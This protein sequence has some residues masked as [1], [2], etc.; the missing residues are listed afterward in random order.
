M[1]DDI[2]SNIRINIDAKDAMETIRLLQNQISAFHTQLS[3]MGAASAADARNLQQNLVNSINASGAFS[4]NFT[5]VKTTA[6]SFTQALEKNKLS[7]GEYFR[8][9]GAASKSF[10]RFFQ[11]EFETINKVARERVKDLQTQYIKLGRDANGAMQAIKV[12]PLMLDMD[13]LATKTQIA[14]QR[15][16][17]LNQLLKQGSTNLLNFG[18]NTQWAGR[19]LMVGFTI[20]LSIMGSAA[21]KAYKDIEEAGLRLKR[22]YGDL[23]TTNMETEKMVKQVQQLA[24]E[25][26]KYGVAVKDSMEMAATAA[27]TGK[28]GADLLAQV[29]SA[30]K[31][32]VL[33]GVDQQKALQTTISLTDAFSVSS[34]NLAENI[35]FL[36]AVE[37]QTVLSIDDMT[38]AIP[39]AA[40]VIKQLGGDVKDLAFF[41]TAMKE[42]GVN[43]SEGANA[44][45]SGLA[46]L[47][48]PTNKASEMLAGFGI[49]VKKIVESNK[50]D[51]SKIVVDFAKALD[52]LDPLNRAQA[53]EQLFGKFQFARMSTLFK[54]VIE[55]GSQASEVL[56]LA[57]QSSLELSMLAQ[58]E[59]NKIQQSPLYKFQKAVADFQ[60]QLAPVG[61]QFMKAVTPLI[62]F[63]TDILKGFNNLEDGVKQFIVKIV[64][65]VGVIGPVLIM[66]F[67]LVAN[68]IANVIKGFALVKDMF[69]RAGKS[70]LSLGEQVNYMTQEQLQA[71]AVASS[72]DQVH[73]KLRQTFT[74]EAAAVDMLT[75][76]Y[77]RS[78]AAQNA[79]NVPI[80]PRGPIRKYA[81]GG[82]IHGP[83][84]GTSDSILA[85]VSNGE[86]II[87]AASVARNPEM[88]KQLVSG[89]IPG[90]EKGT[91]FA[92]I[93]ERKRIGAQ[94]LLD[95]ISQDPS[96]VS[97]RTEQVVTGLAKVFGD[98]FLVN[99]YAKLGMRTGLTSEGVSINNLLGKQGVDKAEFLADFDKQGIQRWKDSLKYSGLKLSDVAE[100]LTLLDNAIRE[101]VVRLESNTI[102]D[103]NLKAAYD[104]A[105]QR[106][107]RGGTAIPAFDVLARTAG[108]ARV[109]MSQTMANEAGLAPVAGG[110]SKGAVDINGI[111]LR[112]G[113]DRFTFY[114]K[115]GF[116]L[117][118]EAFIGIKDGMIRG[119]KTITRQKSPSKEAFDAGANIGKGAI[120][121]IQS[122]VDDAKRA[123]TQVGLAVATGA[124][125]AAATQSRRSPRRSQSRGN[126]VYVDGRG[127]VDEGTLQ[128]EAFDAQFI[129]AGNYDR[130]AGPNLPGKGDRLRDRF[131]KLGVANSL[132]RI[133]DMDRQELAGKITSRSFGAGTAL[134]L[135]SMFVPGIAG[136]VMGYAGMASMF[137]PMFSSK[138][139][140]GAQKLLQ[141][142]DLIKLAGKF[143]KLIPYVG[144]A[145]IAFEVFDKAIVPMIKKN[146]DSYEA[147]SKTLQMTQDRMKTINDFFGTDIKLKGISASNISQGGETGVQGSIS[148][149]FRQ[150]QQ[151]KDVYQETATKLKNLSDI[152][153]KKTL[154]ALTSNLFGQAMEKDQVKAIIDAIKTEAGKSSVKIDFESFKI[155]N[156]KNSNFTK[157]IQTA[158]LDFK[159][160]FSA[161]DK[162]PI[163]AYFNAENV[164]KAG[165]AAS[166]LG[167]YIDALSAS[168]QNGA[169]TAKTFNDQFDNLY[170]QL[171]KI[172]SAN[173]ETAFENIRQAVNSANPELATLLSQIK[174][175]DRYLLLLK[176]NSL[177]LS[178]SSDMAAIYAAGTES[179]KATLDRVIKNANKVKQ[180]RDKVTNAYQR[181]IS[182]IQ[183]KQ[184]DISNI[185]QKINDKYNK[186]IAQIEKIK[187]LNDQISKSQEGQ[188]SLAEAL[189]T[190][191]ISAAARAAMEIQQTS[192][193]NA[194]DR[195]QT[196]LD[197][198][199]QAELKPL[200]NSQSANQSQIDT[201]N[202]KIQDANLNAQNVTI[203]IPKSLQ[204]KYEQIT[205]N[206][207]PDF[208]G[209]FN[210]FIDRWANLFNPN[211]NSNKVAP[212]QT[213][214]QLKK[215]PTLWDTIWNA[216][217]TMGV[218]SAT[219]GYITGPGT[220]TS[221]SIPA[222]LSNGEYVI[223]ANAVKTIGVDVLD[224]LN[225]ADKMKFANGGM[226]RGYDQGGVVNSEDTN[227]DWIAKYFGSSKTITP[228]SAGPLLKYLNSIKKQIFDANPNNKEFTPTSLEIFKPRKQTA[229]ERALGLKPG[230]AGWMNLD[231]DTST[232]RI[233]PNEKVTG[234]SVQALLHE[235]GHSIGYQSMK[236]VPGTSTSYSGTNEEI[237]AQIWSGVLQRMSGFKLPKQN[238][239]NPKT[240]I[241]IGNGR[242]GTG[243]QQTMAQYMGY[244]YPEQAFEMLGLT[245]PDKLRGKFSNLRDFGVPSFHSPIGRYGYA[246]GGMVRAA[247]GGVMVN[248]QI[249]GG[250]AEGGF[251]SPRIAERMRRKRKDP[252]S[253]ATNDPMAPWNQGDYLQF[254]DPQTRRQYW[255]MSQEGSR[256]IVNVGKN[257]GYFTPVVGSGLSFGD[258]ATAFGKGD[259]GGGLLNTAFGAGALWIPRALGLIGKGFKAAKSYI[260]APLKKIQ[261]IRKDLDVLSSLNSYKANIKQNPE[262]Q[263]ILKRTTFFTG[264]SA[265]DFKSLVEQINLGKDYKIKASIKDI[266]EE[267]FD[268]DSAFNLMDSIGKI[269]GTIT[270]SQGA[271]VGQF[272]GGL[273]KTDN[274]GVATDGIIIELEKA[275]RR[276]G[277]G[278][279]LTSQ[280]TE[281]FKYAGLDN[282][283]IN[284]A[285]TDGGYAW[286]KAGFKFDGKPENLIKRM[287]RVQTFIKDK[288]LDGIIERLKS[289]DVMPKDIL[290]A[291]NFNWRPLV[292]EPQFIKNMDLNENSKT[293]GELIMRGSNWQGYMSMNSKNKLPSNTIRDIIQTKIA[294][295][296]AKKVLGIMGG[297]D[298]AKL[299]PQIS[300]K[301]TSSGLQGF[302]SDDAY[303]TLHQGV[304]SAAQDDPGF[305]KTIEFSLGINKALDLKPGQS[306]AYGFL[307]SKES[308]PNYYGSI[309]SSIDS[310]EGAKQLATNEFLRM[311]NPNSRALQSYGSNVIN[312]KPSALKNAT[313]SFGDTLSIMQQGGSMA[314]SVA[315]LS[316]LL[317][318]LKLSSLARKT[319]N[320]LGKEFSM[321]YA[322]IH[323]PSGFG[324][325]DVSSI[326]TSN[327]FKDRVPEQIM[328][329]Q[330]M[331]SRAG[332]G[333]ISV[334]D[335]IAAGQNAF[336]KFDKNIPKFANGGMIKA[337][338]GGLLLNGKFFSGFAGGG[339]VPAKFAMGGYAMGTDT[340][341]AM[342]TPGEFVIKKSAVD[343]IGTAT[344]HKLNG[345]AEGGMVGGTSGTSIGDS[346]YNYSVNVNVSSDADPNQIARAVMTQIKQIDNHRIRSSYF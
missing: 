110:G 187:K 38:T 173:P 67:G 316:S 265:S 243:E 124:T 295:M 248:G 155:D 292:S 47:I 176:A 148:E 346:V 97:R 340:V 214:A 244:A 123:G 341:P 57:S 58:R 31:L 306:P 293:L 291:L 85:M 188:L 239:Y 297:S 49:N 119:I 66:S 81:T 178:I 156:G 342:L 319:K 95:I 70:S 227:S 221:D 298:A 120:Q 100:E 314:P 154:Q 229:L 252:N 235:F 96:M 212:G 142:T 147:V 262:M 209:G 132:S 131:S 115:Q 289:Q 193:Q 271:K 258:A 150:S 75:A 305:R 17:L 338:A 233:R 323:L 159:N 165:A 345:Y 143:T 277:L 50:G 268:P 161:N 21:M 40:P 223:R 195:Q 76:A 177:G 82:I 182:K 168:Y 160:T 13:N 128:Q 301:M 318:T 222:M 65:G 4:A 231:P 102:R 134:S 192:A 190:G 122:S 77:K 162:N 245:V 37:N 322:E 69:N 74:S 90:F 42:G 249:V 91:E 202:S 158:I 125:T 210:W 180:E 174:D 112:K 60:A 80:T 163:F 130:P 217:T 234:D 337:A 251:V 93:G 99:V 181:E 238:L 218:T 23:G 226:V 201:L 339:M 26:T 241:W 246:N 9:A 164:A 39:K 35:N 114:S 232:I 184:T 126:L 250:Y 196:A 280:L 189:N 259:I 313:V 20:P 24:L 275:Y 86:A 199:R 56:K 302:I 79:M 88:V 121:G 254:N 106:V 113:G 151:F 296:N 194:L 274:F 144:A 230:M 253:M 183:Q 215:N 331:L 186:R 84:T 206:F 3:K 344:L 166:Q 219:G 41:L 175:V 276:K 286:A 54:N 78:I 118:G 267:E 247:G 98:K 261:G 216:L 55:Q 36:N 72:L 343:R 8:Y 203:N 272:G 141:G 149:Q 211:A 329:I 255:S 224:R 83:G 279:K 324:L 179:E 307:T 94:S 152:E 236:S 59:L 61:E 256:D 105:A 260:T 28:Q 303:K 104:K 311:I 328:E 171:I 191:D 334:Y 321:P 309:Y 288:R 109:N 336:N 285:M 225:H 198:A 300:L 304:R 145:V 290:K 333:N 45:K 330:Q 320:I 34:K 135:G 92:H 278:K 157:G 167:S 269:T 204:G 19:Q 308:V 200:K 108:E 43:A 327:D 64:S 208:M 310:R 11:S 25:F 312:L 51:V 15:Q 317:T 294:N 10:G 101:E 207:A 325:K 53:I 16:Q 46:S 205:S 22:V 1:A 299:T 137:A 240:N 332:Y 33:G 335:F 284:A 68:A 62:N 73:S 44:I 169:I 52:T 228:K 14:A 266:E 129:P 12:R 287:E 48:N 139:A 136:Q 133:R 213:I 107:G 2:Q 29:S 281:L 116:S 127:Y 264:K 117:V 111:K 242:R 282:V 283:L 185:E 146:A 263:N 170:Q 103:Q 315:K 6:E 220:G 32:A 237:R 273:F 63:G 257:I 7:M 89:N 326:G 27:A 71:A 18:K 140:G 138:I 270:N 172:N 197:E 5:K 153:V 87:P 30:A